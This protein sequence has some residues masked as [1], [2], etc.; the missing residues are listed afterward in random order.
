M[1]SLPND[2]LALCALVF[3]WGVK[4]GF[5][6][7]H[8]ATIDGLTRFNAGRDPRLASWCGSLF[9]LGHGAIVI[10]VAVSVGVLASGWQVPAAFEAVGT[11]ISISFLTAL[12]V[13][14][15]RAVWQTPVLE[16]VR[17]V[18]LKGRFMGPVFGRLQRAARPGMIAGVGA[19]FALSFDTLSQAAL[20][21]LT[22]TQFGGWQHGLWLGLCFMAGMLLCDGINGFWIARLIRT[23]DHRARVASR[24]LG[25]AVGGIALLVA[26]WGA[27]RALS[28][29]TVAWGEGRELLFGLAVILLVYVAYR[30]GLVAARVAVPA[31]PGSTATA[32]GLPSP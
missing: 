2:W 12:G 9:S 10:A 28:P 4:H 32:P 13:L 31:P 5:D 27:L 22:A 16:V 30:I 23:A 26:A 8:L 3:L 17:P 21:A 29:Q 19:I 1:E 6:A 20:F 24:V 15:L 14:N 18:G 11:W 7:D 25:L